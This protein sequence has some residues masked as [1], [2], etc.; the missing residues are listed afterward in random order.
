MVGTPASSSRESGG[1]QG[2]PASNRLTGMKVGSVKTAEANDECVKAFSGIWYL[3]HIAVCLTE[4]G[5]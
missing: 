1:E 2:F 5:Q 4:G 3:R